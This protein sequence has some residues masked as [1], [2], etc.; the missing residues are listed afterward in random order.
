MTRSETF[1][2]NKNAKDL[3]SVPLGFRLPEQIRPGLRE[4][5]IFHPR[6]LTEP[7]AALRFPAS[8]PSDIARARK[9]R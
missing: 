7:G 1:L 6:I 4:R 9:S 2:G 3:P 8:I 5:K